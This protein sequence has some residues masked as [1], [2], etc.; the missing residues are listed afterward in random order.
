[1]SLA[2]TSVFAAAGLLGSRSPLATRVASPSSMFISCATTASRTCGVA[3]LLQLEDQ[4]GD[5]V[6]LLGLG[7]AAKNR[8]AWL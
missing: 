4:G 1:M 5:D 6:V 8:R 7:L 3:T 2:G